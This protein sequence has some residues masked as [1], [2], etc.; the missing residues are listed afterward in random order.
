MWVAVG[1]EPVGIGKELVEI[2]KELVLG[3]GRGADN[4]TC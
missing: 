1:K 3:H 2:G 4:L